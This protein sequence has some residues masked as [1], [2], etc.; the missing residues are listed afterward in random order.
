MI[1]YVGYQAYMVIYP[2]F[3]T[4]VAVIAAVDDSLPAAG[5]VVRDETILDVES[6]GVLNYLVSNG[7]KVGKDQRIAEIYKS[8][9]DALSSLIIGRLEEEVALLE[10]IRS[11][12]RTAGNNLDSIENRIYE[13]LTEL[14]ILIARQDLEALPDIRLQ[15]VELLNSYAQAVNGKVDVSARID[16]INAMIASLKSADI[17]P[18]AY[19]EAPSSGYFISNIDSYEG[20]VSKESVLTAPLSDIERLASGEDLFISTSYCKLVSDYS[21]YFAGIIAS[22]RADRFTE[23]GSLMIDFLNSGATSLPARVVAVR[24]GEDPDRA[25]V[26]LECDLFNATL[27]NLRCENATLSF[28]N[29]TGIIVRRSALHVV[30]GKTGVYVRSGSTVVFKEVVIV[31]ETADYIVSQP[32]ASDSSRLALYDEIIVEGK[33][34]YPGKDLGGYGF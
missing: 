4:E 30:N 18:I 3:N 24:T 20:T 1:V 33:D 6:K 21:W 19:M 16:G 7:D 10:G 12:N 11:G 22:D 9:F 2:A 17:A 28:R 14:S 27:V 13:A 5:I 23:G 26:I 34:L 15:L 8:S 29:H 25:V 32:D 31:F